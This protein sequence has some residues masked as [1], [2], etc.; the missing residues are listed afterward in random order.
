M[1]VKR[2]VTRIVRQHGRSV[3]DKVNHSLTGPAH[4]L[5]A[6]G[7]LRARNYTL[8]EALDCMAERHSE[9]SSAGILAISIVVAAIGGATYLLL[10]PI[11]PAKMVAMGH[12]ALTEPVT[13]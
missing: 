13:R 9:I 7:V 6:G 1:S 12:A 10:T 8:A 4:L 11:S 5:V 2:L 3:A